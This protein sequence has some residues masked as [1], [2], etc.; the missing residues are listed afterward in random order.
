VTLLLKLADRWEDDPDTLLYFY[1]GEHGDLRNPARRPRLGVRWRAAARVARERELLLEPGAVYR[2]G[3]IPAAGAV[4][5]A[6]SFQPREG[7][8]RVTLEVRGGSGEK[9]ASPWRPLVGTEPLE[10]GTT[11]A[12]ARAVAAVQPVALGQPFETGF[13]DTWLPTGPPEEQEVRFHFRSPSGAV[14]ERDA[15]YQ[16]DYVFSVSIEPRELGRWEYSYTHRF[17][18]AY[19]SAPGVFD[20]VALEI[21]GVEEALRS[22]LSDLDAQEV[23]IG[24]AH[25]PTLGP[26]FWRLER[27]LLGLETPESFASPEGRERFALLTRIREV[28]GG[29]PAPEHPPLK[30]AKRDW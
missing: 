10:P 14:I 2:T 22:L 7:S 6:A 30:P 23:E 16:G 13:R 26:R 5:I 3:R 18:H 9:A 11:W 24:A 12:E 25:I 15:E 4:A 19:E 8:G 1:S 29:R 17:E 27:A 21:D 28:L 20:V